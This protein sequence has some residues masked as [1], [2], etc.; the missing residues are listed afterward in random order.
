[1]TWGEFKKKI[2]SCQDVTD[3]LEIDYIDFNSFDADHIGID[4]YVCNG[5]IAIH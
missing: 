1:M 2:N 3:D 5:T 4:A